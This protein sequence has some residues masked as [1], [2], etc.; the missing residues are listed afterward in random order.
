MSVAET[1]VS[2]PVDR[3]GDL[4]MCGYNHFFAFFDGIWSLDE[5]SAGW[6]NATRLT[7]SESKM[8]AK[9]AA[10]MTEIPFLF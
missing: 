8:A 6:E 9:M 4:A 3:H 2:S 7:F 5:K 1:C 10:D